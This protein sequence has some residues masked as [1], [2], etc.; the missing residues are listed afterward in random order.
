MPHDTQGQPPSGW[1]WAHFKA[2]SAECGQWIWG[3]VEGSFNHKMSTSQ[4]I[5][6]AVIGCIPLLGDA[7]AVRDLIATSIGLY[8]DP[9]KREDIWEWI[10]FGVLLL[11]LIPVLG[12]VVKGV[13]RLIVRFAR[14]AAKL[15]GAARA[16]KMAETAQGI[17]KVL[18]HFK[19]VGNAEQWFLRL[20][21]ADYQGK[22]AKALETFTGRV[23]GALDAVKNKLS[24]VLTKGMIQRIDNLKHAMGW[25]RVEFKKRIPEVIRNLD[26]QLREVQAYVRSG[27]ETTS[28]TA[29]HQV[30]TGEKNITRTEEARLYEDPPPELQSVRGGWKQNPDKKLEQIAKVYTKPAEGS[31]YPDLLRVDPKTGRYSSIAAFSGRITNKDLDE[32]QKLF[33]LFGPEGNTLGVKIEETSAGGGWWGLGDMPTTPEAWRGP[34]GVL[35]EFNRDGYGVTAELPKNSELKAAVG[36]TSEQSGTKIAGQY[37]GGGGEQAVVNLPK[38]TR[39]AL[40]AAGKRVIASGKPETLVDPATGITFEIRK[41]PWAAED[42][43]GAIG[44]RDVPGPGKVSTQDLGEREIADKHYKGD[45][46]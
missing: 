46:P 23:S 41:T 11:A 30:A 31:G 9:K 24:A 17:I 34:S 13:G 44:Y 26:D 12:G 21:F 39:G 5:V 35:D 2:L 3:T 25:L 40:D 45:A 27:G 43:N 8:E 29:A 6:D 38:S 15:A 42:V 37:L 10:L 32:G 4:I 33:R 14:D 20:R 1:T 19:F 36:K 18:N 22:M 28:K 16:V 7:T